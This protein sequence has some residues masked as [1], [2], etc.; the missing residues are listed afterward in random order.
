M[1]VDKPLR[2]KNAVQTLSRLNRMH[3]GK[4]DTLV[5]D[6]TGSY[7][8]IMEAYKKYQN[9]VISTKTS[10][11]KQLNE[12]KAA[13]LKFG[14]FTQENI[15]QLVNLAYSGDN[16]N[17][18]AIAGLTFKIKSKFES[19]LTREKRDEFRTLISRY[20]GIFKYI[21]ALFNIRDKE[22]KDFQL[23]CI[24]LY[25]KIANKS[26][27]NLEKELRDV[28][29]ANFTIAEV[30]IDDDD[31]ND[32]DDSSN[33]GGSKVSSVTRVKETKTVKEVVEEINL[34][35]K[36]MIGEE[37]VEV[38]G[39][40]LEDVTSDQNLINILT[41]NKT[42]DAE[43]VYESLEKELVEKLTDTIMQKAPKKYPHIMNKNVLP[44]INRSAY[45]L[46]RNVASA[47]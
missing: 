15:T 11:P 4:E 45:N 29:V 31:D 18:P 20:I 25:N 14:I 30:E 28:S 21:N 5:V 40:F 35:F 6:F 7:E 47:I 46:L 9:D 24:Y 41:N 8:L 33:G 17:M 39:D 3:K 36:T 2:D 1:F 32:D 34:Q 43:R 26:N 22:L 38:I 27:K 42:Q 12:L 13:L 23:F 19:D 10:D 44:Y 16:K 37:G